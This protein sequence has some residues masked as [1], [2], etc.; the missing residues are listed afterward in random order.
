VYCTGSE[1]QLGGIA[2][3]I[4]IITNAHRYDA[5]NEKKNNVGKATE[6][7][8]ERYRLA[9]EK[10]VYICSSRSIGISTFVKTF[11]KMGEYYAKL[12]ITKTSF[13]IVR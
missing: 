9:G 10:L 4:F 13:I 11:F 3:R 5:E 7:L 1:D 6:Q 2:Q 12:K 8:G